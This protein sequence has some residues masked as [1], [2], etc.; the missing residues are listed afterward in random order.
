MFVFHCV[1]QSSVCK[2]I[3]ADLKGDGQQHNR[4]E[5]IGQECFYRTL[6]EAESAAASRGQFDFDHPSKSNSVIV[7]FLQKIICCFAK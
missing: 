7:F 2:K 3:V 5:I 6:T 1:P 4:V